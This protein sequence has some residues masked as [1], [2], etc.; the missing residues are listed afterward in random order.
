[1]ATAAA[2]VV[3][4]AALLVAVEFPAGAAGAANPR[5]RSTSL[6][7]SAPIDT[8]EMHAMAAMRNREVYRGMAYGF[9]V[10]TWG[11][12]ST[13]QCKLMRDKGRVKSELFQ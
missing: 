12:S 10:E 11:G 2:L 1:M 9:D 4:E 3:T 13:L 7:N 6:S 5:L 8:E